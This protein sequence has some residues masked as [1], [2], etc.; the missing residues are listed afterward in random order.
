MA[1]R[2][3]IRRVRGPAVRRKISSWG[4]KKRLSQKRIGK[5]RGAVVWKIRSQHRHRRR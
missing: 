3:R 5:I 2:R 4:R 1:R